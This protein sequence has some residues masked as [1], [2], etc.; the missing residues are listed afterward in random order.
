MSEHHAT[1]SAGAG[2]AASTAH[3]LA[4]QA[5]VR[6]LEQGGNAVDA[7]I[8]AQAVIGVVLPQAAGLGGDLLALVH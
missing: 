8:A 2:G 3:P 4:T 6:L 1:L 5:A 7:A